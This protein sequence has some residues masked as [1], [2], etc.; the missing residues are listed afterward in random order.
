VKTQ[1]SVIRDSWIRIWA[2][3]W[4]AAPVGPSH[5]RRVEDWLTNSDRDQK[6][7]K[8]KIAE[9]FLNMRCPFAVHRHQQNF[10]IA[11]QKQK[12]KIHS[13]KRTPVL[14]VFWASA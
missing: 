11:I 12:N 14:E 8:T 10:N 6:S 3:G 1:T 4:A 13:K 2:P 7:A 5:I 9:A